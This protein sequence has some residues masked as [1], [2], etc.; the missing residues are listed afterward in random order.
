M[1]LIGFDPFVSAEYAENLGVK[2][3]PVDQ[4]LRECDFLTLHIPMTSQTKNMIG[5]KE[6]AT[7]KPTARVI[8]CARGG[9]IDEQALFDAVEQGKIAGAAV[10]VFTKEPAV[11]NVL[12]K[13]S[14]II[15][16][17]HLGASTTEA[18]VGVAVD[19]AEQIIEVLH[20]KPARYAVNMPQVSSEVM[21]A[22]QP[23]VSVAG[24]LGNLAAQL[25]DGQANSLQITYAGEIS[26][27]DTAILKAA[28]IGGLLGSSSEERINLINAG[29]IATKRGIKVVEQKESK[30]ENYSSL[31]TLTLATSSGTLTVSGTTM[32][33][34]VHVVRV[35]DYWIDIVPTGGYFLFSDHR[36]RPGLV[37]AVGTITGN[38]DINI[39]SMQLGRL[40]A[41]GRALMILALDE[42]LPEAQRK[43]I[44]A[45]KNVETARLVKL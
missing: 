41:R 38:A 11:E 22:L 40:Q 13:S 10:D 36:D 42:A 29:V 20:G 24:T 32:R 30:C 34:T 23:F 19:V 39:S 8:N 18:Q 28:A 26:G 1:R 17:P 37:G 2:L 25:M 3:M 43:Q 27:Y 16:T 45:L 33:G 14:K 5:A 44:L 15:V 4:I 35:N 6:L 21:A 7:M 12:C 9:L 31:L